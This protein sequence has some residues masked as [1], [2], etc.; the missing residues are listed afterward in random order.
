MRDREAQAA[1]LHDLIGHANDRAIA[2]PEDASTRA[3]Q[4]R[5]GHLD[6]LPTDDRER[7]DLRRL[8]HPALPKHLT[9]EPTRSLERTTK[10]RHGL[11]LALDQSGGVFEHALQI[12]IAQRLAVA[13]GVLQVRV[14]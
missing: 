4:P 9:S 7:I 13:M 3:I 2:V 14:V 5:V 8:V 6:L 11:L 12:V 1:E 10:D